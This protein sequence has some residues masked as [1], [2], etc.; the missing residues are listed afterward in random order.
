MEIVDPVFCQTCAARLEQRE[1]HGAVRPVCPQC[2]FVY[3]ADPK[4]AVGVLVEDAEGRLLYTLRDHDPMMGAWALPA[5]MVDRGEDVREAAVRE[6][7]EETGLEVALGDLIG[8]YSRRGDPVVFIAFCGAVTG[9]TLSPGEEARDVRF[10]PADALP[11]PAFPTDPA[12]LAAWRRARA[13]PG[14]SASA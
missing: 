1:S 5:G 12:V 14:R 8:V 6:V 3:F 7:R 10:F 13:R 4:V 2:A 9:G 11:P